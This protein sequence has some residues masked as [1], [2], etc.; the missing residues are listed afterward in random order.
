M[1]FLPWTTFRPCHSHFPCVGDG[2]TAVGDET[3]AF[4]A[5]AACAAAA[6]AAVAAASSSVAGAGP[7][8]LVL[9]DAC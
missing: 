5:C 3:A 4:A 2:E 7:A 6:Y 9:E 1:V 8:A